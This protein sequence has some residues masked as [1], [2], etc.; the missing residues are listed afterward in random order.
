MP[1]DDLLTVL[2]EQLKKTDRDIK[3]VLDC[4]APNSPRGPEYLLQRYSRE[5]KDFV[6]VID[7]IEIGDGDHL[8]VV[9]VPKLLSSPS[10]SKEVSAALL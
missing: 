5:W 8:R 3:L 2:E 4:G 10:S 9:P 7:V 1:P 6:D